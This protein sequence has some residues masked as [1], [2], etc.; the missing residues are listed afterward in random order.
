MSLLLLFRPHRYG[1]PATVDGPPLV[2]INAALRNYVPEASE[3]PSPVPSSEPRFELV[4]ATTR[5]YRVSA[6]TRPY[7]IVVS[8]D[9]N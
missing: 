4:S 3:Y 9:D 7:Y 6:K 5:N 1:I 8:G 2:I